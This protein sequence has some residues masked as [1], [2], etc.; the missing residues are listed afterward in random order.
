M[1]DVNTEPGTEPRVEPRWEVFLNGAFVPPE[2]A[3]VSV[4]DAGFQHAIGVFATV[5]VYGGVAFRLRQHLELM[6]ASAVQLGLAREM[7]VEPL[8]EA[9]RATI[10]HNGLA[11]L[12]RARIRVTVT[13]GAVSILR[14]GEAAAPQQTVCI[15]PEPAVAYDPAYF[16]DGITALFY[17]QSANPFDDL[18]GHKTLAYWA[19]LR[20]LRQ[21]AAMDAG[22]A[23]W[24]SVTNHVTCGAISNVILVKDGGLVTPLARGETEADALPSPVRP[25]VTRA[26][27]LEIAEAEGLAVTKKLVSVEEVLEADEVM[28]TNAGWGVLPVSRME[29]KVIGAGKAGPITQ[30][31][32]TG[33]LALIDRECGT[34]G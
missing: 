23:L 22:E 3:T 24:L 29:Q 6:A 17:K 2:R 25:G 27:V 13:P 32:R 26:A 1:A 21:A 33:L 11:A 8:A 10:T 5:S 4:F 14:G 9:V 16:E 15:V 12:E 28:L 20:S 30:R 7:S 19:R 34:A 31:L 18:A